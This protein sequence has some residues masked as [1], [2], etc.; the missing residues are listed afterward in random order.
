MEMKVGEVQRELQELYSADEAGQGSA[1]VS[2]VS[3]LG[4]GYDADVFAFSLEAEGDGQGEGLVL[5]L[6]AGEGAAEK[7]AREFAAMG[8]L[9]EAGYPV[10]RV[11][12][13]EHERSPFGRPLVIM[14]RV[15]G[16]SLGRD[17]WAATGDRRQELHAV[18]CRLMV[19]LHAL[20]G[21]AVLPG[22]PLAGSR[23]P[24]ASIDRDLA[25]LSAL[26]ERF[27][28]TEPPSLRA[29][30]DWLSGH[31]STVPCERLAVLH[32]DFHPNNVLVRPDGAGFVIDWSNVRL[33]DYRSDLA[34]TR[35]LT[36][37]DAQP[38]GGAAE[39]RCYGQLAGAKVER[40]DYFE[41]AACTRLLASTLLSLR[42]GTGRQGMRPGAVA[43]MRRNAGHM[44]QYVAALLQKRTETAMPD[45]EDTL[46]ALLGPED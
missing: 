27:E 25:S 19:Q 15:H 43:L 7:A 8:H 38:D 42:S 23:D 12:R 35:L 36:R 30:L 18:L 20:D 29:A 46:A 31:R 26:L 17:Y 24:Y 3:L 2:E 28:G 40:I 33:G 21:S 39:L 22:S 16:T 6:Y 41:A 13:L 4:S 32:G 11:L 10:P 44:L 9:R 34:W 1:R 5:R 14:E 45:L 37:S